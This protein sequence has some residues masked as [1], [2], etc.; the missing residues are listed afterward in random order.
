MG[1]HVHTNAKLIAKAACPQTA[2][3]LPQEQSISA[4][5]TC[6]SRLWVRTDAKDFGRRRCPLSRPQSQGVR[7][8]NMLLRTE[9]YL[10][11]ISIVSKGH[12]SSH[13][14]LTAIR[15]E[16]VDDGILAVRGFD[17]FFRV[18]SDFELG[19]LGDEIESIGRAAQFAAVETVANSLDGYQ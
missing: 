14:D 10:S 4:V 13:S 12:C 5:V 6:K 19:T 17:D 18:S 3:S 7:L 8:P 16:V 11:Q 9:E 15:A 1:L 2:D